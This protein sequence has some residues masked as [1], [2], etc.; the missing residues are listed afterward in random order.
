MSIMTKKEFHSVTNQYN[1][2]DQ[3]EKDM[4]LMAF[5]Q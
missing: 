5:D 4:S 2:G 3:E 1:Q